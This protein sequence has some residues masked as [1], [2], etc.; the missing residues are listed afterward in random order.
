MATTKRDYYE[1]LGLSRNATQED[2]RKAFRKLAF[3]NHPDRNKDP[4][5]E[6]RF[7][8]INE[9]Y[10]VLSDDQKRTQ[11][12]RFGHAGATPFGRGFEG[13]EGFGGFGDIFDAFFGGQG[14]AARR[15][16][17]ATVERGA[18]LAAALTIEFEEACLGAEREFEVSR[19]EPC[20]RCNGARSEPGSQLAQCSSCNGAGEVRRVER[21]IFGQF[22]NVATCGSCRG[23]GRVV[24]NPCSQCRGS[25]RERKRKSIAVKI[26][27]GVPRGS[28]IR[29][30][31]EGELG[32]NGGPRGNL[33]VTLNVK[34]HPTFRREE[35]DI[36]YTLALNITQAALGDGVEVPTLNGPAALKVPAGTQPGTVFR[37]KGQGVPHL[38]GSGRGDELVEVEVVIP[39]SL[40]AEQKRLIEELGMTLGIPGSDSHDKGIF[41]RIKDSF[42]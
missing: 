33:Y 3:D 39:R 38:R 5:A 21:S 30:R 9:A 26:P 1:V 24:T 41:D 42:R 8:E 2:I 18:D 28:Q 27:P 29:L 20:D 32:K 36:L 22:V 7:K 31:G 16:R 23:E 35:N 13:F 6:A 25:G 14:G 40:N 12:D 11:F 34:E 4:G 15:G 10:E 19:A 17:T 37:L